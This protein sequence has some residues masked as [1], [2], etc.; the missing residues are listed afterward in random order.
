MVGNVAKQ[1]ARLRLVNDDSNVSTDTDRPEVPISRSVELMKLHPQIRRVQLQIASR[2]FDG[3]F[4]IARQFCKAI[5]ECVDDSE[6]REVYVA[7]GFAFFPGS[8][9]VVVTYRLCQ[10]ATTSSIRL[11]STGG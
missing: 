7:P 4:L 5:R 2:R 10:R 9:L 3:P 11:L 6:L 1:K 8:L